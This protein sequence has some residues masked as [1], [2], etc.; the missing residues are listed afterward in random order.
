MPGPRNDLRDTSSRAVPCSVLHLLV[1]H[2][3]TAGDRP[4]RRFLSPSTPPPRQ[5]QASAALVVTLSSCPSLSSVRRVHTPL[6]PAVS[7][8]EVVPPPMSSNF[9]RCAYSQAFQVDTTLRACL[10]EVLALA[11]AVRWWVVVPCS[12]CT[13]Q[14]RAYPPVPGDRSMS[15]VWLDWLLR[16]RGALPPGV[17]V[18][19]ATMRGL[20]ENRGL[21]G[22][23]HHIDVTYEGAGSDDETAKLPR[24]FIL[25]MSWPG[26]RGRRKVIEMGHAR[27][28]L[29]YQ[30]G[31]GG[32]G[33]L[34]PSDGSAAFVPHVWYARG[35]RLLGE[36]VVLMEDVTA[37]PGASDVVGVNHVFG[38]QVWGSTRLPDGVPQEEQLQVGEGGGTMTFR[39]VAVRW[40]GQ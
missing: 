30:R 35:S 13:G 22:A 40:L 18:L 14:T 20:D 11:R 19:S 38:N 28:A 29:L 17:R 31:G 9:V 4:G 26:V 5:M 27:E 33:G 37:R 6:L 32:G 23:I 3:R 7:S 21:V 12:W 1:L 2:S 8:K 25:K 16:K 36:Y 10:A 34:L 39:A 15:A 24:A